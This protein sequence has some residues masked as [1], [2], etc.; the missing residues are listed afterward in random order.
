[1]LE[2]IQ[3]ELDSTIAGIPIPWDEVVAEVLSRPVPL[4]RGA[5]PSPVELT[6]IRVRTL[7][8]EIGLHWLIRWEWNSKHKIPTSAKLKKAYKPKGELLRSIYRVCVEAHG[9]Q[10]AAGGVQYRHAAYWFGLIFWE[11]ILREVASVYKPQAVETT[12]RARSA[13]RMANNKA[14]R[15]E[16]A[17]V[18]VREAIKLARSGISPFLPGKGM[19]S[20]ADLFRVG[21]HLSEVSDRF[22]DRSWQPFLAQWEASA[23]TVPSSPDWQRVYKQ[24]D[25]LRIQ[26]G[27]GRG[28]YG[29]NNY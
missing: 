11:L 26:A 7:G 14:H 18:P 16:A 21:L 29:L 19:D 13:S 4:W 3:T 6:E 2:Q 23:F 24:G 27:K 25:D 28:S 5:E 10:D 1:M 15:K 22:R 9:M 20:L 12:R 8:Y 17:L